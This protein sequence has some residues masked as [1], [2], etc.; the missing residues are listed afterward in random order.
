MKFLSDPLKIFGEKVEKVRKKHESCLI[1][2]IHPSVDLEY[3]LSKF[4]VSQTTDI[5]REYTEN[6]EKT[7]KSKNRDLVPNTIQKEPDFPGHAFF[8]MC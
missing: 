6:A 4:Q 7:V 3:T 5:I 8:A 1:M 2:Q